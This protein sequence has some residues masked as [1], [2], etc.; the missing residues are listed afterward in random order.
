[1]SQPPRLVSRRVFLLSS[2]LVACLGWLNWPRLQ[3]L[4]RRLRHGPPHP[5]LGLLDD[6]GHGAAIG[7]EYL[8]AYADEARLDALPGLILPGHDAAGLSAAELRAAFLAQVQADFDAGRLAQVDGWALARSE[9]RL[10][11]LC[12]LWQSL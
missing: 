5:L 10:F 2:L 6:P 12:A 4:R 9:A 8:R 11:G 1:M 3:G 7:R